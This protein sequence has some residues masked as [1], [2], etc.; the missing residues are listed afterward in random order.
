MERRKSSVSHRRACTGDGAPSGAKLYS[1]T[2]SKFLGR[3][4]ALSQTMGQALI[5]IL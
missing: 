1:H 2:V 3:V 5:V 4:V